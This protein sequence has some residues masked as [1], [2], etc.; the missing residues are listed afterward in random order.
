MK[1]K[2]FLIGMIVALLLC[3]GCKKEE[4]PPTW[5]IADKQMT[6]SNEAA[7]WYISVSFADP[8]LTAVVEAAATDWCAVKE[9]IFF[10]AYNPTDGDH[11]RLQIILDIQ[12]NLT[13]EERVAR[14]TVSDGDG[15]S[16]TIT[17]TQRAGDATL[18]IVDHTIIE[19]EYTAGTYAIS[20][21]SNASWT[22][23]VSSAATWCTLTSASGKGNGTITVSVL[24]TIHK[25]QTAVIVHTGTLR[26]SVMVFQHAL[27]NLSSGVEINGITWAMRNVDDFGEFA[28]LFPEFPAQVFGKFYQY[29]RTVAYTSTDPLS[30]A[31]DNTYPQSGNWSL[32]NDPCPGGWRVASTAEYQS[33]A[34]SGWRWVTAAESEFG[35]P[36]T[37][38]GPGAQTIPQSTTATDAVFFPA[39]GARAMD[40]GHFV[41]N[42]DLHV[43]AW[44]EDNGFYWPNKDDQ[45]GL[46]APP[47]WC[48]STDVY[49]KSWGFNKRMALSIRC[50][51]R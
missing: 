50:V 37:W 49:P 29:N 36:G 28:P 14:V 20:V 35:V 40:D 33:L 2:H 12:S 27:P 42:D 3:T 25:R 8:S 17:I 5:Q 31:W 51:K 10:N 19:L 15:R 23:T 47:M 32:I 34:A 45:M 41:T 44:H 4:L 46:W 22:A 38:F 48:D 13:A 30:P 1:T 26:D 11:T 24:E 7:Q 6:V 39:A 43:S 9:L 21:T 18:S 16:E